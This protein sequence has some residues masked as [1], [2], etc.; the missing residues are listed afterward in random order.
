M[1]MKGGKYHKSSNILVQKKVHQ[2]RVLNKYQ[3]NKK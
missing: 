2:S 3:K 1:K